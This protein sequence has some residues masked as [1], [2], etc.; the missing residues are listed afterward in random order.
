METYVVDRNR[1]STSEQMNVENFESPI[2]FQRYSRAEELQVSGCPEEVLTRFSD[3]FASIQKLGFQDELLC[4]LSAKTSSSERYSFVFLDARRSTRLE[5]NFERILE[6]VSANVSFLTKLSSGEILCDTNRQATINGATG[7]D[8]VHHPNSSSVE[9]LFQKHRARLDGEAV[10]SQASNSGSIKEEILNENQR[11]IQESLE[12]GA[13]FLFEEFQKEQRESSEFWYD[14]N[15]KSLLENRPQS[16]LNPAFGVTK[17]AANILVG[18]ALLSVLFFAVNLKYA[19]DWYHL[20]HHSTEVSAKITHQ[21]RTRNKNTY[22]HYTDYSY[23]HGVIRYEGSE[24]VSRRFYNTHKRG[25]EIVVLIDQDAPSHSIIKGQEGLLSYAPTLLPAGLVLFIC[26]PLG[27][28]MRK[29]YRERCDLLKRGKVIEGSVLAAFERKGKNRSLDL[30]LLLST[31]E[32]P[33]ETKLSFQTSQPV[34]DKGSTV[35]VV[36]IDPVKLGIL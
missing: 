19:Y 26:V 2:L 34:P 6:Q 29:L 13:L 9:E 7:V 23:Q 28:M 8:T 10:Q 27:V 36:Y 5:L 21:H 25:D 18:V 33:I 16:S 17:N 35:K 24:R 32:G 4:K 11:F 30:E 31:P 14:Y 15:N 1:L 22:T 20:E 3:D 12:R